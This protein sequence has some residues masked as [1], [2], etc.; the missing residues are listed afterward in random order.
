MRWLAL[1]AAVAA[2]AVAAT[3]EPANHA[4]TSHPVAARRLR[5]VQ[6]NARVPLNENGTGC[7]VNLPS[8]PRWRI[9]VKTAMAHGTAHLAARAT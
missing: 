6:H 2:A 8:R 9:P 5:A 4:A 7:W 3:A 1:S